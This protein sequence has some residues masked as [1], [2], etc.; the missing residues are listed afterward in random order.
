MVIGPTQSSANDISHQRSQGYVRCTPTQET[1]RT[2]ADLL[3]YTGRWKKLVL[4][5]AKDY[6]SGN[7][8]VDELANRVEESRQREK[9][10]SSKL[11][12]LGCP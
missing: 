7:N 6:S 2:P 3:A 11:F 5:S 4:I 12:Y 1:Q 10:L 9:C 8:R